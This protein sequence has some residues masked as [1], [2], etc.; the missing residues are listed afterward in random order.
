MVKFTPKAINHLVGALQPG[1]IIRVGVEGGGCSG[2]NYKL[3]IETEEVDDEDIK[4]D[5]S[6]VDVYVDPYSSDILKETTVHYEDTLMQKG[7]KFINR[8]ANATCGCG[9]SFR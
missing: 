4:L 1:E 7:F 9:S 5:I 6:E 8:L 3:V 2:M